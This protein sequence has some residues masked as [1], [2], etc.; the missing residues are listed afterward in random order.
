MENKL[1]QLRDTAREQAN[2]LSEVLS[3]VEKALET[4]KEM[5]DL[6]RRI[7]AATNFRVKVIDEILRGT[8]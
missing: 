8:L 5:K 4:I 3:R 7:G 2:D 1:K 6:D